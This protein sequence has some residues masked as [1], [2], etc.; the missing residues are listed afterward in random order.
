LK[1]K[2]KANNP[3]DLCRQLIK[4]TISDDLS[5]KF[6]WCKNTKK[7]DSQILLYKTPYCKLMYSTL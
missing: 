1:D 6:N 7:D 3:K 5:I 4:D 2:C